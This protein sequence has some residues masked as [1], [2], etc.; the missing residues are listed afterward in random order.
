MCIDTIAGTTH[1]QHMSCMGTISIISEDTELDI[2]NTT[3]NVSQILNMTTS[4][5]IDNVLSFTDTQSNGT[6]AT[7]VY[8]CVG[9]TDNLEVYPGEY[10][11][12][13]L[14]YVCVAGYVVN[15]SG[16]LTNI[17][18]NYTAVVA[19]VSDENNFKIVDQNHSC[20]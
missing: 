2:T 9:C 15:I 13:N 20:K 8:D 12:D 6:D 14:H 19:E 16:N 7:I 5:G 17:T 11:I 18:L 10:V 1:V 3:L 4:H